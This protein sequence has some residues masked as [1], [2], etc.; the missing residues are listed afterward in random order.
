VG[1]QP[2]I[3]MHSGLADFLLLDAITQAEETTIAGVRAFFTAPP[4]LGI[5]AL[6][7]L[8][9]FH[10]RHLT[11]FQKH[12]FLLKINQFLLPQSETLQGRYL[13]Q[14]TL[15][16]RSRA[17][18]VYEL[19]AIKG[20]VL[21]FS[22]NFLYSVVDYDDTFAESKLH[23]HYLRIFKC[24]QNAMGNGSGAGTRPGSSGPLR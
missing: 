3:K 20:K 12:A 4:W 23:N 8:G 17:A 24:L 13:L 15:V 2:V 6:A 9:A 18:F 11:G 7:Q 21:E 1:E 10:A 5:E 19:Q 22:G 16:S 14:G